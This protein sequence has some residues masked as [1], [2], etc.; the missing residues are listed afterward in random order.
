LDNKKIKIFTRIRKKFH[1][2]PYDLF[3]SIFSDL[4]PPGSIFGMI[5]EAGKIELAHRAGCE[6]RGDELKSK[7]P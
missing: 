4:N 1:Y 7:K 2:W 3:N 6:K 5:S